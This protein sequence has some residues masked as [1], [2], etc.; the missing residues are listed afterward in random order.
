MVELSPAAARLVTVLLLGFCLGIVT[1]W[2][3]ASRLPSTS[4]GPGPPIVVSRDVGPAARDSGEGAPERSLGTSGSGRPDASDPGDDRP[5][6][7][8]LAELP[9]LL[10]DLRGRD[11][12]LPIDRTDVAGWK[13]SFEQPR[14]G[15]RHEAVDLLAPRGTPVF[16]VD[17]G[18]VARL[19]ESGGG[20]ISIYQFDRARRFVYYYAHLDR[21]ARGLDEGD[22]VRR[23][24]VIGYVGTTGNAPPDTPHLHFAIFAVNPGKRWREGRPVDPYLAYGGGERR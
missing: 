18:S 23:G 14:A 24:E 5:P 2:R 20:G 10:E 11:L 8:A 7:P 4:A 21:Y 16:A 15:H 12:R 3:L 17:D 19:F 1:D 22:E 6:L 9:V 13:G